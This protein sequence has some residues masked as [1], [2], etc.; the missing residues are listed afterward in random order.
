MQR[1]AMPVPKNWVLC[2]IFFKKRGT[3]RKPRISRPMLY[4]FMTKGR[5]NLNIVPCS[6]SSG[7][8]GITEVSCNESDD[9]EEN[10][11]CNGFPYF[12]RKQN[13]S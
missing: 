10:S 13:S 4:N 5:T 12:R 6:P 9:D 2:R 8:S 1:P 3:N 11:S 7:S